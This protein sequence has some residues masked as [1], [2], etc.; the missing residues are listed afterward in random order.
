[1]NKY[2]KSFLH[3]GLIFSGLGPVVMGIVYFI[4][5]LV[6]KEVSFSGTEILVGIISTYVLAFVQAGASVFNQIEGWPLAKSLLIHL[7]S[8]YI[9]YVGAYLVNSWIPFEPLVVLIFSG[10]FV[11]WD[12]SIWLSVFFIPRALTKRMNARLGEMK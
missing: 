5:S 9:V 10:I 8:L 7:G 12:F 6:N 4:I 2:V 11:A 1:M 3:R